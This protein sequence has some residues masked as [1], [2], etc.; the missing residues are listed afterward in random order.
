MLVGFGFSFVYSGNHIE[1][2][3]TNEY[4]VARI[5]VGINPFGFNWLLE[6]GEVFQTPEVVLTYSHNGF[7]EMSRI[8]HKLYRSRLCRG[9]YRDAER[10]I[11]INNW[12]ATYFD[13]NEEK[14]L[15]IAEKAKSVGV[16]LIVLDDGCLVKETLIIVRLVIGL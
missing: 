7:G 12:E 13:F 1:Q 4:D 9:K 14:I 3:E 2:V 11:L 15:N 16:E 8:Y 5:N 10:P 6:T